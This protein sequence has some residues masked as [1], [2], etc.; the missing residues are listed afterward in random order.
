[1]PDMGGLE[2]L[3]RMRTQAEYKNL[4]VV[5]TSATRDR[6]TIEALAK[7]VNDAWIGLQSHA[8]A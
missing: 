4:R 8:H 6:K 7:P 2:L 1:M 5:V 3:Q